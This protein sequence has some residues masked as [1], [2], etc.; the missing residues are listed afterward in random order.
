MHS[1]ENTGTAK[2]TTSYNKGLA[3][4]T[5][6]CSILKNELGCKN[7]R[8]RA[9][10]KSRM[11]SRGSNVDIIGE[12][13][14]I[15]GKRLQIVGIIYLLICALV[16]CI[17]GLTNDETALWGGLI[18]E[19]G[20]AISIILS[21]RY[22]TEHIWVEC[23]NQKAKVS[24]SQMQKTIHEYDEYKASKNKEFKFVEQYFVSAS[25]FVENALK[26]AEE[27]G[28][29]CFVVTDLGMKEVSY[30]NS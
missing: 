26:L 6:F 24:Y 4:E 14:D 18:F 27:R 23:K 15:R 1:T 22:T 20:G 19:L 21:K 16:F 3:L 8:I 30:W 5:R 29:R 13:Q 7:V 10:M 11:N 2:E 17:G 12:R 28:V 25:G 9:Q